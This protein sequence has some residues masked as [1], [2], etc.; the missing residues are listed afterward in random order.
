MI[1]NIDDHFTIRS[2]SSIK[3]ICDPLAQRFDTTYFNFV[4]RYDDGSEICLTTDQK[5]TK[6][7]YENKL[8]TQ[9]RTDRVFIENDY[10]SNKIK[11]LPWTQFNF[12]PVREIQ[13]KHFGVGIGISLIFIHKGYAD[14]F[15]FGTKT[16]YD[17]MTG[18]YAN[19]SDCLIQF[20]HYFYDKAQKIIEEASQTENL[21]YLPD[22][23]PYKVQA[24]QVNSDSRI[25]VKNFVEETTPKRFLIHTDSRKGVY[26]TKQEICCLSLFTFGMNATEIAEKL[27]LSK[28]TVETHIQNL[29]LKLGMRS[30]SKA[31]VI[32]LIL[33]SG[34]DL[35]RLLPS[36]RL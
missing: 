22:R 26:L 4:R 18:V 15:H 28:R 16:E 31:D 8:Y 20:T 19:F 36:D 35:Q 6:F 29:K 24:T 21:I 34:F 30:G 13:S 25:N 11:V 14:F 33:D 27:F 3:E 2:A 7:F 17:H 32:K 5:W 12:S 23:I 10:L 1:P 9:V